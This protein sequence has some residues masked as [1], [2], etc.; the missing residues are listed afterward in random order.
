[1]KRNTATSVYTNNLI[2]VSD[3]VWPMMWYFLHKSQDRNY[4]RN[5][6]LLPVQLESWGTS[7]A[8]YLGRYNPISQYRAADTCL[9]EEGVRNCQ[10][11]IL[12]M[13]K[14]SLSIISAV[15]IP[16]TFSLLALAKTHLVH[17]LLGLEYS[18]ILL[19]QHTRIF[20][21]SPSSP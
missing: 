9:R 19:L 6:M 4:C 20:P 7:G 2:T 5:S 12:Q 10:S 3:S 17:M 13:S 16:L 21:G 14:N 15:G 11:R 8:A 1:M 18:S